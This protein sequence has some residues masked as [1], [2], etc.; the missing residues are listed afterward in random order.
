MPIVRTKIPEHGHIIP[1]RWA[2]G[3]GVQTERLRKLQYQAVRK[4]TGGYHGSRQELLENIS[5][6]EPVQTKIWD[7]QVRA[8]APEYWKR[9]CRGT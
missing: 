5:K 4:I 9:E 2:C 7:M 1:K 6:V 3:I 8:A